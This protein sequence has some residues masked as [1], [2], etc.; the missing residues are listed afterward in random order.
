M[1]PMTVSNS[2][3]SYQYTVGNSATLPQNPQRVQQFQSSLGSKINPA[4]E[5]G[6]KYTPAEANRVIAVTVLALTVITDLALVV[7]A[8]VASSSLLAL[9][10]VPVTLVG[11]IVSLVYFL[12]S[13]KDLDSPKKRLQMMQEIARS[14][15]DQIAKQYDMQEI[16]DYQLL[17]LLTPKETTSP[18][19]R[20]EKYLR[21]QTLKQEW[22]NLNNWEKACRSQVD[23]EWS[24]DTQV[25]RANKFD[26]ET[27]INNQIALLRQQQMMVH[28]NRKVVEQAVHRPA[29]RL[30]AVEASVAIG[31]GLTEIQLREQL[32]RLNHEYNMQMGPWNQKHN[33]SLQAITQA[34]A[35]GLAAI[36]QQFIWLKNA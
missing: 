32:A 16:V 24:L 26:R 19:K 28:H 27:L 14:S 17:D 13:E 30:R 23:R 22:N 21:V 1:L 15:F 11:G 20:A 12:N 25:I 3:N 31:N 6:R 7:A 10:A 4:Y 8:A 36:E 18:E 2:G 29:P 9:L 33:Q 34:H 5:S 35:L